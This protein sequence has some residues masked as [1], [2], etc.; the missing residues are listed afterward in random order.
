MSGAL[1]A[2]VLDFDLTIADSSVAATEC[3]NHALGKLGF[4]LTDHGRVR[5]T[6]GLPLTESF[7]L[8]SGVDDPDRALAFT[9]LWIQRADEVMVD[10]VRLYPGAPA[11]ITELR[12]RGLRTAIV[13]TK[14]RYRIEAILTRVGLR[15]EMDVIVGGEDVANFKPHPEGIHYALRA[16]DVDAEHAIYVGDHPVDAR[17][18]AAAEVPFVAVLTGVTTAEA[19]APFAPRHIIESVAELP[20][21]L[22]G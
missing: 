16:L 1:R 20:T 2:V 8:L 21:I 22:G 7:R 19:W 12:R 3:A 18:A 13:S 6:I 4:P 17:A 15:S 9:Q 10:L 5:R 14:F 11:A